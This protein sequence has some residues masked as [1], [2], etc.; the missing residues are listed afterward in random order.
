MLLPVETG[1]ERRGEQ[2]QEAMVVSKDTVTLKHKSFNKSENRSP[3]MMID[4]SQGSSI[5]GFRS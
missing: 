2:I 1:I 5:N 4:R 3:E